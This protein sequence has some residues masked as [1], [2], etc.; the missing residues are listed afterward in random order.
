M[1][2]NLSMFRF[3]IRFRRSKAF[4]SIFLVVKVRKYN[5]VKP[6][7]RKITYHGVPRNFVYQDL[8]KMFQVLHELTRS[9][10]TWQGVSSFVSLGSHV[11]WSPIFSGNFLNFTL[12]HLQS[13]FFNY[14]TFQQSGNW[15]FPIIAPPPTPRNYSPLLYGRF[16]MF[17]GVRW[18]L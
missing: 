18:G 17:F 11:K 6:D 13:I 1:S 8:G 3:A 16:T 2:T 4:M 5:I 9:C 10:M 14:I 7:S 15:V 12:N